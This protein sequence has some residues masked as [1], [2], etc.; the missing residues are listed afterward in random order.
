MSEKLNYKVADIKLADWGRKEIRI[1]EGEMPGLMAVRE[2]LGAAKPLAGA[3]IAGCLHMTI[4]TAVLIETLIALGA[5]VRIPES[6][7]PDLELRLSLYRRAAALGD[8]RDFNAFAAELVDRF[9]PLPGEVSNLLAVVGLKKLCRQ[10]GV[11]KL[12][13]GPKGVV[14]SFRGDSF[15]DPIGLVRLINAN[16]G[17]MKLRP[18]HRLVMQRDFADAKQR[19]EGARRLLMRLAALAKPAPAPATA[20][21]NSQ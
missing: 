17:S 5:E 1:A 14:L 20:H 3:R 7:V 2:E 18:D 4:Q 21:T 16:A 15:A 13:A 9:G 12:D 10:A 19:L 11:S 6:Y 8:E